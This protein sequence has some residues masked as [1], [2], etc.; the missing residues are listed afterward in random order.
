MMKKISLVHINNS[1]QA[2]AFL[3]ILIFGFWFFYILI[4]PIEDLSFLPVTIFEPISFFKLLS[5]EVLSKILDYNFLFTFRWATIIFIL[6]AMAGVYSNVT[7]KISCLLIFF[8]LALVKSFSHLQHAEMPPLYVAMVLAVFRSDDAFA[9]LPSKRKK[10]A[11]P[12][13][14]SVAILFIMIIISFTYFEVGVYRLLKSAPGIFLDDSMKLWAV[15]YSLKD[16]D[17]NWGFGKLFLQYPA[18]STFLKIGFPFV[19]ILEILAPVSLISRKF[20]YFFVLF[21]FLFH[22]TVFITMKI[23]FGA[24]SILYIIFLDIDRWFQPKMAKL[25]E[26]YI[27]HPSSRE[28]S[29]WIQP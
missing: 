27:D 13:E 21:M 28:K 8:H 15:F 6:L 12:G 17:Y 14:Y 11:S 20:K 2:L 5:N 26:S 23:N 1:P 9:L 10:P 19:T 7:A 24:L 18:I 4:D 16:Q 29:K 25:Q 3:R 22:V